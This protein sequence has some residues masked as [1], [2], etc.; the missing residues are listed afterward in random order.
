MTNEQLINAVRSVPKVAKRESWR[1]SLD[2]DEGTLFYSPKVIPDDSELHQITDEFALYIDRDSNP[3]GVVV[4]Y[5]ESNFKKHH[6]LNENENPQSFKTLL[7]DIL[8]K[9]ARAVAV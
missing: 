1:V 5:F 4:E 3:T 8:L 6:E 9:Q 7:E 2:S